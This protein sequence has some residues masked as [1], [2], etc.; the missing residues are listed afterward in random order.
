MGGVAS[1]PR[2][3]LPAQRA[4][5]AWYTPTTCILLFFSLS[6]SMGRVG[7]VAQASLRAR[8][9]RDGGIPCWLLRLHNELRFYSVGVSLPTPTPPLGYFYRTDLFSCGEPEPFFWARSGF[10]RG[11]A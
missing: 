2:G 5:V 3:R 10:F 7:V 9:R 4:A 6:G 8:L 1:L 11:F